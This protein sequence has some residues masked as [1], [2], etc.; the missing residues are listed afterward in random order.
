MDFNQ[1]E[2]QRETLFKDAVLNAAEDKAMEIIADAQKASAQMLEDAKHAGDA[3]GHEQMTANLQQNAEREHS[4]AMQSIKRELLQ[5]RRQLVDE[6]FAEVEQRL[7]DF[8]AGKT[9][10]AW[11]ASSLKKHAGLDAGK[12]GI[13]VYLRPQDAGDPAVLEALPGCRVEADASI[14]LGGAR[15]SN[16]RVLFDDTIDAA[17]EAEKTNFYQTSK[18]TV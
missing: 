9:Y 18:L 4:A 16:G 11:L 6:L 5:T 17:L 13:V 7:A 15:V 1:V 2:L 12:D 8:V 10:G 14:R 3:A